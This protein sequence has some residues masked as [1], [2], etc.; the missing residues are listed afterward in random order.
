MS[1]R[2]CSLILMSALL[3]GC[4]MGPKSSYGF[5]LPDGDAAVGKDVFTAMSCNG[6]HSVAG[7]PEL[8]EGFDPEL[9]VVL[10]GKTTRIKSYGELVTS[11]INP[12]HKL[13]R[14]YKDEDVSI[15]GMSKMT[16]Y[17]DVLTVSELIDLVAFLQAQ[18]ELELH[19]R[20]T[21]P[22]YTY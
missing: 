12:S 13:A 21:Y 10:G 15:E 16:N 7:M 9:K 17:N 3:A 14:G 5:T 22:P 6:C 8:R 20:T 4:N 19:P 2:T 18:Y 1:I 11:I